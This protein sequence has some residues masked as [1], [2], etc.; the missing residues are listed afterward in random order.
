MDLPT[1]LAGDIEELQNFFELMFETLR[2]GL[3]NAGWT[4]PQLTTAQITAIATPPNLN[5]STQYM[6]NGTIWFN[7]DLA[8]LQVQTAIVLGVGATVE[9]VTSV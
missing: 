4:V 9:T 6:P 2:T 7:T 8:K 1:F 5:D 3:S